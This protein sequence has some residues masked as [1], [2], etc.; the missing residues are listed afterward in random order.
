MF[1]GFITLFIICLVGGLFNN[2]ISCFL[3]YFVPLHIQN[4]IL[5]LISVLVQIDNLQ[6]FKE[7]K[8]KTIENETISELLAIMIL[9]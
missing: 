7:L 1:L 6:L 9:K 3:T 2:Y 4:Y 8:H 5:I